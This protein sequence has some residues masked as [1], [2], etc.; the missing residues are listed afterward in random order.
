MRYLQ[1][2]CTFLRPSFKICVFTGEGQRKSSR[3]PSSTEPTGGPQL[4]AR[5]AAAELKS[6]GMLVQSSHSGAPTLLSIPRVDWATYRDWVQP[7]PRAHALYTQ[8]KC[9]EEAWKGTSPPSTTSTRGARGSWGGR[10]GWPAGLARVPR[11]ARRVQHM[12]L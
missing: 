8:A 4:T 12:L 9:P 6:S 5:T 3:L 10:V 11:T 2:N 7:Q 1:C